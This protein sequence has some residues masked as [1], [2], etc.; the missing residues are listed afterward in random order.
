MQSTLAH[1]PTLLWNY[2]RRGSQGVDVVAEQVENAAHDQPEGKFDKHTA[3]YLPQSPLPPVVWR[4]QCQRCQFWEE[5]EPGK[6]GSCHIVGREDDPY[7]GE[8][9]HP[10]GWCALFT[11]PS[12]EPAFAWLSERLH[13]DGASSVRGKYD[14]PQRRRDKAS[15]SDG[16]KT[17]SIA[18]AE[19]DGD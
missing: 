4:N 1:I 6:A 9:I 13:P 14:P 15:T 11:P 3:I 16:D 18:E 10:R 2:F 8:A 7:G 12:E 17:V 5:G 19:A